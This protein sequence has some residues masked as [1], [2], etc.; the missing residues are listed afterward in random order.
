MG[1]AGLREAQS[2]GLGQVPRHQG[3]YW[4]CEQ[5]RGE[6]TQHV[7]SGSARLPVM[8]GEPDEKAPY[9]RRYQVSMKRRDRLPGET[10]MATEQP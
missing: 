2:C 6:D 5:V 10:L 4:T 7:E 9:G 1:K 3:C 8:N